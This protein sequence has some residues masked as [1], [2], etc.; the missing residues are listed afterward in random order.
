MIKP[1]SLSLSLSLENFT[2]SCATPNFY[3]ILYYYYCTHSQSHHPCRTHRKPLNFLQFSPDTHQIFPL[4]VLEKKPCFKSKWQR[5]KRGQKKGLKETWPH[6]MSVLWERKYI[7]LERST[8]MEEGLK[9]ISL[10]RVKLCHGICT[11]CAHTLCTPSSFPLCSH[12]SSA[13]RCRL[14]RSQSKGG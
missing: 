5:F 6:Q 8:K 11:A 14:P 7:K 2:A 9:M 3:T 13:K 12:L 1:R 10:Q 4:T